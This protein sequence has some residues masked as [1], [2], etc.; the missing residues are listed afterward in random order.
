MVSI[1]QV[2]LSVNQ[3]MKLRFR[4][5]LRHWIC[6]KIDYPGKDMWLAT[7]FQKPTGVFFQRW[8]DLMLSITAI[9]SATFGGFRTIRICTAICV[10][11]ITR[12]ELQRRSISI[13]SSAIIIWHTQRLI[14]HESYLLDRIYNLKSPTIVIGWAEVSLWLISTAKIFIILL[15]C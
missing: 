4:S 3:P 8:F 9:S 6:S 15:F 13:I 11:S 2:S 14:R 12:T 1:E 7:R 10:I 5:C